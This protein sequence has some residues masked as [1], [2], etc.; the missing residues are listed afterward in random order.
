MAFEHF[1]TATQDRLYRVEFSATASGGT[2]NIVRF[3]D[4]EADVRDLLAN[5]DGTDPLFARKL[6]SLQQ[7]TASYS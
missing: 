7:W 4:S 3:Y 5:I 1:R 6:I 2:T